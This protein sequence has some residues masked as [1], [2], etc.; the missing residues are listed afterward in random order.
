MTEGLQ[1]VDT[2][3]II[4]PTR[5]NKYESTRAIIAEA[6]KAG[7]QNAVFL[8]WTGTH[9]AQSEGM[10]TGGALQCTQ[11]VQHQSLENDFKACKIP[12]KVV[13]RANFFLQNFLTYA[14]QIV[15]DGKLP[16]PLSDGRKIAPLDL[17]V[18]GQA[19]A[20]I[21]IQPTVSSRIQGQTITLTGPVA[22]DAKEVADNLSKA[23]GRLVVP[24]KIALSEASKLLQQ[25]KPGMDVTEIESLLETYALIE[26]GRMDQTSSDLQ[27]ILGIHH[28][29]LLESFQR[30][31]PVLKQLA[32]A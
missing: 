17:Q 3:V 8:S 6:E 10:S 9:A 24:E 20:R 15:K 1:G 13:V 4:P 14:K 30:E 19:M 2:I 23:L 18:L 29:T 7:V 11:L 5:P 27:E 32:S 12:N 31:A 26:H 16:V 28:P 21:A 22:V 25:A